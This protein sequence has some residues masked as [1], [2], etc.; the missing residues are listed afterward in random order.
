M[1]HLLLAKVVVLLH[2]LL[3]KIVALLRD[4]KAP[5]IVTQ[6]LEDH[7]VIN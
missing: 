5:A 1:L 3:A 2:L 4:A 6:D 7:L